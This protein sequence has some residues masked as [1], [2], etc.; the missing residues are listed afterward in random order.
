[1]EDLVTLRAA[2]PEPSRFALFEKGFR[3]FFL[4]AALFATVVVPIWLLVHAGLIDIGDHLLPTTWHAHEMVFGYAMAVVTGFLLTAAE[5]WTSRTTARG[6]FL[7]VLCLAWIVGRIAPLL[8]G[9]LPG[10]AIAAASLAFLPLVALA[11]GRVV[12]L[13]RSRRNYGLVLVLVALFGAQILTHVGALRGSILWQTT[14]PRLGVGLIIV[15]ILVIGGRIIPLF[16]RNATK[17]EGIRNLVWVDRLGI[18]SGVVLVVAD[19][20]LVRGATIGVIATL[21]AFSNALRMRCWGTQ[22]TL[23]TPLLWVLHVGYAFVPLGFGLRAL[24]EVLPNVSQSIALHALT[25]GAIGTLTLGMMARVSLGHTGRELEAPVSI[26]V[27]FSLV[28]LGA[29]VRVAGPL[30]GGASTMPALHL[31]GTVWALAFAIYLVRIGPYL[32]RSRPDGRPG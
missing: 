29:L 15:I 17:A 11:V 26:V 8:G 7:A 31:S 21:A 16:T 24:A 32:L 25:A 13:A 4:L 20:S 10:A 9:V 22:H 5:N 6:T 14:G 18:A 19:A 30:L 1:M 27:A 3:P 28:I 2:G 12:V 23:R